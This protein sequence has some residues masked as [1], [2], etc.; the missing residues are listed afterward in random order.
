[1]RLWLEPADGRAQ[2]GGNSLR[3]L[4]TRGQTT[5]FIQNLTFSSS[6][7]TP[8]GDGINDQLRA[9]YSLFHLP[10]TVPVV[11]EAGLQS[12]GPQHLRWDGRDESGR[13]LPPGLYL[14]ALDLRSE[15][16]ANAQYRP[17]GIAY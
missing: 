3:V 5:D 14:V 8:N 13:R 9:A 17:L 7:F 1:M 2:H 10:E 6:V 11:L 12:A 15:F 16:A 4:G